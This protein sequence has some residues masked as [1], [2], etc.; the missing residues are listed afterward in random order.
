MKKFGACTKIGA[1]R[2]SSVWHS[3]GAWSVSMTKQPRKRRAFRVFAS[4]RASVWHSEGC[5]SG[6]SVRDGRHEGSGGPLHVATLHFDH[7]ADGTKMENHS[8]NSR[9]TLHFDHLADGT[10]MDNHSQNSRQILHF[11]HLADEQLQ[12]IAKIHGFCECVGKQG[13]NNKKN[14]I[15]R[16]IRRVGGI[17]AA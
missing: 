11:D 2:C 14:A 16:E 4:W 8:Q 17:V 15:F 13:V 7:L 6:S 1:L 10:K 12:R 3:E 9:Q 5:W